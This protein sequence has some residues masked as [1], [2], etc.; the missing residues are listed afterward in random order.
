MIHDAPITR[1]VSANCVAPCVRVTS[2]SPCSAIAVGMSITPGGQGV[3]GSAVE[4]VCE[5]YTDFLYS[6]A[7]HILTAVFPDARSFQF[8]SARLP[9]CE[10]PTIAHR[11][12][13]SCPPQLWMSDPCGRH[14]LAIWWWFGGERKGTVHKRGLSILAPGPSKHHVA[15]RVTFGSALSRALPKATAG[16]RRAKR[17]RSGKGEQGE[18][19]SQNQASI[20]TRFPSGL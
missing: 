6:S 4:L 12:H 14:V 19:R 3:Q 2:S 15:R 7:R 1:Y 8:R 20:L 11:Q 9:G 18:P 16:G 5:T 10:F 13:I 17:K